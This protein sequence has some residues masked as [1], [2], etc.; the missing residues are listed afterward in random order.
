MA[1]PLPPPRSGGSQIGRTRRIGLYIV[2]CFPFVLAAAGY[3]GGTYYPAAADL[4]APVFAWPVPPEVFGW[5]LAMVLAAVVW[6]FTQFL[7]VTSRETVVRA[8][9]FDATV[10]TL[11]AVAFT[12]YAGWS[13]GAAT[14]EWWLVVPWLTSIVDALLTGWL[15]INNAAQKPFFGDTGSR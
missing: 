14:V 7:L 4:R 1:E 5:L 2:W 12:G 10:S 9:Q 13:L 3:L 8:L 6:L 11:T 15:G